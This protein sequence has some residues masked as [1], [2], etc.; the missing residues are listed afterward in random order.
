MTAGF[1]AELAGHSGADVTLP[2]DGRDHFLAGVYRTSLADLIDQ[3]V[4]AGKRDMQSLADTVN[5]Q[6][7]VLAQT[8]ALTNVNAP[9]DI[10]RQ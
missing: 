9:A 2:W 1:V 10:A 7:I 3:L 5:T 8:P 4:A 6:R